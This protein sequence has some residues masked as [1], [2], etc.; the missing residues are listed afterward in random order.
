MW[1][2][3]GYRHQIIVARSTFYTAVSAPSI[4]AH[5]HRCVSISHAQASDKAGVFL[6]YKF[7]WQLVT[8]F[9]PEVIVATAAEQWLSAYQSVQIFAALGHTS[10]TVR[11]GFFA[12]MG[13]ITVHPPDITPFP[14]DSQQLAYLVKHHYLE[15]PKI[16]T[17]DIRA[18]NKADGFARAITIAQMVWFCLSCLG[19]AVEHIGLS[20]LELTT[21]A[22][23]LC[24]LHNYFF[25]HFK[26]LDPLTPMELHMDV[27]IAQVCRNAG[28]NDPFARS[29]LD[30]VKPLPD[31]KS[32]VTPFWFG[33]AVVF[34][35]REEKGPSP[36]QALANS[37][38][39]PPKGIGLTMMVYLIVF[40]VIYYGLHII[41]GWSLAFPSTTE[42]YLWT[43]SNLADLGL[44]GVYLISL[45]LGTYFAPFIGRVVFKKQA[46]SILEVA[47]MLPYWAK[48]L[49]HGPFVLAYIVARGLILTESFIS[50][51]GLHAA[52]YQEV[53][54]SVSLPHI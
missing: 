20:P 39:I 14:I 17:A 18:V 53:N 6:L 16:R 44:I 13:G 50:L 36:I 40:Q 10:W 34:G 27:P 4:F 8:I 51:R 29:P 3:D 28:V 45:P 25:W 42:W 2:G 31:P 43:I 48:L 11:H 41:V 35:S 22:F 1:F 47:S 49:I 37:R 7:R 30:F 33:F 52:I 15:M 38:N 9:F 46:S 32:L 54:W 19:R 26:P 21:L 24:T 5:G 12:D 23:I